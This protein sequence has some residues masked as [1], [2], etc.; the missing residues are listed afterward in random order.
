MRPEL[1]VKCALSGGAL[2]VSNVPLSSL[3]TLPINSVVTTDASGQLIATGTQLTVGNILATTTATS[4]LPRLLTTNATTTSL[5]ISNITSSLLKTNASGSVIPAIL[6]TDYTNYAFPFTV[7]TGYNST[8]TTIGFT[9][10]LFSTASSTFSSSLRLSSLSNGELAVYG[11]LVGSYATTTAGTGLTYS[12]N[13]FNVNSTQSISTLSNLTSNGVVYTAGGT[14]TLNTVS[15]STPTI[16]SSLSY[17]GTVGSFLGG[18][19]GT[20]SLNLA[21]ANTWSALQTFNY[22]STTYG[23]FTTAS[24]T[25]LFAGVFTLST[26]SVGT[27]KTTA[28]GSVYVDTSAQ[29]GASTTLLADFNTFSNTNAFMGNLGIGTTTP[30]SK[31]S[32]YGGN[33]TLQTTSNSTTAFNILNAATTSVFSVSTTGFG[34]TTVAG[35][36]ISGSATSTS[37]VG[38][39]ITGGCFA[40]NGVCVGS[41]SSSQWTTSGSGIYYNTG[42]VAI[43]TTT[44]TAKLS[45]VGSVT[46]S[47]ADAIAGIF[48]STTLANS[49]ASGFQFGNRFLT[50]VNG[51][52]AGTEVGTLM[53]VTDNTS[54]SNTVRGLEVQAYSGTNTSGVNTGIVG[55]GKTFGVQGYTDGLAGGVATPAGLLGELGNPTVGNAI[56]AYTATGTSATLLNIYQETS[57]FTG[58]GLSMDLG[59]GTGSFASGNFIDL[60]KAGVSSLVVT[61]AGNLGIGTSSPY[62]KLGVAGSIVADSIFATT[63]ATSTFVGGIQT[64]L[65]NVISTTATSSFGNGINITRGCFAINGTCLSTGGSSASS[66]LLARS[67]PFR[68]PCK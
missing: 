51:G 17:S 26:T 24:T 49:T 10:G 66:T 40:V 15:T 47:G 14:G 31:L 59:N 42:T 35:L 9:N 62:V 22:S 52:T 43:G 19:S 44:S 53:R 8:S 34:T 13:A 61:S 6:G 68:W 3:A 16:G 63:T 1:L 54:L 4:T 48:S 30:L 46:T 41:G 50:T 28:T 20:L 57:A 39:N 64:N 45:V 36:N 25:N 55:Y 58:T 38:F 27:L 5:A 67:S 33:T 11:G 7:N 12:G 32:V 2:T 60:K 29:T 65:L 37:N 18:A 23:S 56:R 21:N